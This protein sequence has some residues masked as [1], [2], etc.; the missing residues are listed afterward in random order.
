MTRVK[1]CGVTDPA[2]RSAALDADADAVGV[3]SDVPVDTPREVDRRQARDLLAGV[4][5]L[6]TGVLVTMATAVQDAVR[7]VDYVDPDAL[8]IHDGLAPA[9]VGALRERV[10]VPVLVGLEATAAEVDAY[11]TAAD[12]LLLDAK[13]AA[14]GGGT[15][16]TT[17]W[18]RAAE[19]VER[20][21]APVV[22]AGGLGPDTVA[23]AVETVRPHGVD[24][25]TGV[26]RADPAGDARA[27]RKAPAAVD[28]FVATAKRAG[29]EAPV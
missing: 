21:D 9:Q 13:D 1:I 4:P 15:G 3:I 19:V 29:R 14:G 26:E 2:D 28:R 10:D 12:A 24:V 27:G 16:E 20:V 7:Q 25:A 23:A 22:L 11:A 18:E 6:V 5:P 17:D 8:Q